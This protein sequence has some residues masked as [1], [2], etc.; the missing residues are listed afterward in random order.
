M[1]ADTTAEF[2]RRLCPHRGIGKENTLAAIS[3]SIEIKPFFVEFDVQWDGKDL[4]LGHPP[5]I[6]KGTYLSDALNLFVNTVTIPKIDLKLLNPNYGPAMESLINQ[7]LKWSPRKAIVNI[8]I[9]SGISVELTAQQFMVAETLLVHLTNQN[10][11]LNI[12]LQR[13]LGKSR[14]EVRDHLQNL[15]RK[16]YSISPNLDDN[17]NETISFAKEQRIKTL[18]FWSHSHGR[19]KLSY[20]YEII[21]LCNV[22]GL[23]AYFDIRPENIIHDIHT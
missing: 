15:D 18:Q 6:E 22:S 11:L 13:Y 7:L 14:K 17:I 9:V 2:A 4:C 21:D 20:L 10:V 12:D 8:S 19:H 3:S 23:E 1:H 16:P 5:L